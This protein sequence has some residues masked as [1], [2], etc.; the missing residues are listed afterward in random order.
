MK[1]LKPLHIFPVRSFFLPQVS[2]SLLGLGRRAP[3]LECLEMADEPA[4]WITLPEVTGSLLE[5]ALVE[6]QA[7]RLDAALLLYDVAAVFATSLIDAS[8]TTM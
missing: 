4:R 2:R 3:A 7:Y 8:V 6:R 1:R 5:Q